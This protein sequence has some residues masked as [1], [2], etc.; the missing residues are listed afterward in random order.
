MLVQEL[1]DKE[2]SQR[3]GEIGEMN[4]SITRWKTRKKD[5]FA[6]RSVLGE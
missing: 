6:L 3:Q 4:N 2:V 5:I 1:V